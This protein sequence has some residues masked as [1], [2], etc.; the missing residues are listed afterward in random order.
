VNFKQCCQCESKPILTPPIVICLLG[1]GL[2]ALTAFKPKDVLFRAKAKEVKKIK[3]SHS[4]QK[5]WESHVIMDLPGRF[6]NH[7]CDANVGIVDND[8]GAF[9]FVALQPIGVAEELTWV[10]S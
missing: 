3:D 6:I 2:Y 7:S 5:D 4:I 1:W 8:I 9:D 10:S